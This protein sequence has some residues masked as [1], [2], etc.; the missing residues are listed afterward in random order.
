MVRDNT[1][2]S[3]ALFEVTKNEERSTML[4]SPNLKVPVAPGSGP[5]FV[6]V[7]LAEQKESTSTL[8]VARLLCT[9]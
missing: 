7:I 9:L 4:S 6:R 5:V 3:T 8:I 1:A 2:T